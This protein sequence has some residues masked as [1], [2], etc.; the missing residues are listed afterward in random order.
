M[1]YVNTSRERVLHRRFVYPPIFSATRVMK[2][3]FQPQLVI[4]DQNRPLHGPNLVLNPRNGHTGKNDHPGLSRRASMII[5]V[6]ATLFCPIP[7]LS[8]HNFESNSYAKR[9]P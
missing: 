4:P 5:G 7:N 8:R 3:V 1:E 2:F 6:F 9:F